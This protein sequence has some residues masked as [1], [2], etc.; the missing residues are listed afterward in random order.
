MQ[1]S[2]TTPNTRSRSSARFPVRID[3]FEVVADTGGAGQYQR[4]W[5]SRSAILRERGLR[6]FARPQ[7][8]RSNRGVGRSQASSAGQPPAVGGD[9]TALPGYRRPGEGRTN[10][11]SAPAGRRRNPFTHRQAVLQR[12][13]ADMFQSTGQKPR[14]RR[15]NRSANVDAQRGRDGG[16]RRYPLRK[17]FGFGGSDV[18]LFEL[19]ELDKALDLFFDFA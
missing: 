11:D 14:L 1:T 4:G 16:L 17:L 9:G 8:A 6:R 12:R 19:I 7:E 3:G 5:D 13:S 18:K 2:P 15:N 10:R